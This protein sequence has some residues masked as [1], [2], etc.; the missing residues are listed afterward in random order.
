MWPSFSFTSDSM[1]FS[2]FAAGS[3]VAA[4]PVPSNPVTTIPVTPRLCG[5]AGADQLPSSFWLFFR[6]ATAFVRIVV[7][8]SS[9]GCAGSDATSAVTTIAGTRN[10]VMPEP[11]EDVTPLWYRG[12][13]RAGATN[14]RSRMGTVCPRT[15]R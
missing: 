2:P 3:S 11:S 1:N 8:W 5:C 12:G 14:R 9:T 10:F 15:P 13:P 6:N 4:T 7:C